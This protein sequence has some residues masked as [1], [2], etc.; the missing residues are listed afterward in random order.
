MLEQLVELFLLMPDVEVWVSVDSLETVRT[1]TEGANGVD[2]NQPFV[3]YADAQTPWAV[4]EECC[5]GALDADRRSRIGGL[6]EDHVG[7]RCIRGDCLA[8]G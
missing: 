5:R 4:F 8:P 7:L 1:A 3:L 2:G 6:L